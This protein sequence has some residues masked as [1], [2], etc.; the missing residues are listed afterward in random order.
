[1]DRQEQEIRRLGDRTLIGMWRNYAI[2]LDRR[3]A[4]G[5]QTTGVARDLGYLEREMEW[6]GIR[7][8][9]PRGEVL[10]SHG[11]WQQP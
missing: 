5:E 2:D 1:M 11:V 8:D 9:D 4:A 3:V 10:D 7:H 6:R